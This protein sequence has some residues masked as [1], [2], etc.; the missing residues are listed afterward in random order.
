MT[1]YSLSDE[2]YAVAFNIEQTLLSTGA[3]PGKYYNHLDLVKLAQPFVLELIRSKDKTI[4]YP[5]SEKYRSNGQLNCL[6]AI[7]VVAYITSSSGIG[8]K[9]LQAPSHRR[10]S[11]SD[12]QADALD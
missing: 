6:A 1:S 3:I 4:S 12:K 5:S 11:S 8:R 7:G 9:S 10:R 2:L